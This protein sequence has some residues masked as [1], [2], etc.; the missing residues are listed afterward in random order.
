MTNE[1][2]LS[3]F[4]FAIIL[5]VIGCSVTFVGLFI[6]FMFKIGI[7]ILLGVFVAMVLAFREIEK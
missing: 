3:I 1:S 5:F 6:D 7:A 4:K 2:S